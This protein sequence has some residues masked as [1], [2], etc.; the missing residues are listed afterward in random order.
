MAPGT[1]DGQ[2]VLAVC[3]R[4]PVGGTNIAVWCVVCLE[5]LRL[6][7]HVSFPLAAVAVPLKSLV[8]PDPSLNF[9]FHLTWNLHMILCFPLP[10]STCV[11][12]CAL[13]DWISLVPRPGA[14]IGVQAKL[15]L[16]AA[17][18]SPHEPHKLFLHCPSLSL[19][20]SWTHASRTYFL[21]ILN[22]CILPSVFHSM[23]SFPIARGQV[24]PPR[25]LQCVLGSFGLGVW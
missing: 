23:S 22:A 12:L 9:A 24:L 10:G 16:L 14:E 15:S 3:M 4:D 17:C 25:V 7:L 18:T 19:F 21:I 1:R 13:A 8:F 11:G 6:H 2:I 5:C 20:I